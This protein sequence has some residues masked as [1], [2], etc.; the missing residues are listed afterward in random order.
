MSLLARGIGMAAATVC[1]IIGA[2][3]LA[4]AADPGYAAP[5]GAAPPPAGLDQPAEEGPVTFATGWYLRGDLGVAKD[6]QISIGSVILPRGGSFPNN[7]SFGLGAGYKFSD[8]IRADL[9]LD[10][11]APRTF[12]GN[13]ATISCITGWQ[14]TSA[15]TEAPVYDTCNDWYRARMTNTTVLFNLY[16][17]LG[18]WWGL[19]PYVGA[20]VGFNYVYQKA[21]QNWFMSNGR[22]YQISVADALNTAVTWYYNL[23]QQ[24]SWQSTQL[25]WALMAGFS[26]AVTPNVSVDIGARYLNWAR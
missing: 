25:A 14:L 22:A 1:A 11:R 2:T 10:W 13:T 8:W 17:D 20:G 4:Q 5:I 24:R 26:Y 23:D 12:S 19:T 3:S 9:T 18:T 7:W 21:S 16:A 15:T 6:A